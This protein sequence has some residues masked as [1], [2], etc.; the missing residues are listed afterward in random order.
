MK[1][2]A[3]IFT[4]KNI[5]SMKRRAYWAF[6]ACFIGLCLEVLLHLHPMVMFFV[7]IGIGFLNPDDMFKNK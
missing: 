7:I 5:E 4:D 2:E 1:Q 6:I 3:V